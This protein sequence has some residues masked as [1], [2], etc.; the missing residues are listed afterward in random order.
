MNKGV[1]TVLISIIK[2]VYFRELLDDMLNTSI[3]RELSD[4]NV[5][6]L[7]FCA[8]TSFGYLIDSISDI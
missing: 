8:I 2:Q 7:I 6:M 1:V 5:W 4:F 3:T